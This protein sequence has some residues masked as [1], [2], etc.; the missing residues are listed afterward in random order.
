MRMI[1]ATCLDNLPAR[2]AEV[3]KGDGCAS[4]GV[5]S[6][7]PTVA[8]VDRPLHRAPWVCGIPPGDM[9]NGGL[10][11]L[12]MFI[13]EQ[14]EGKL[15]EKLTEV[16]TRDGMLISG[17]PMA[18][19]CW[20]NGPEV[21]DTGET[22][23]ELVATTFMSDPMRL[24]TEMFAW[25]LLHELICWRMKRYPGP[26]FVMTHNL[27]GAADAMDALQLPP[28]F[29]HPYQQQAFQETLPVLEEGGSLD[30]FKSD[31]KMFNEAVPAIGYKTR[32]FRRVVLPVRAAHQKIE[33]GKYDEV[34]LDEVKDVGW[35]DSLRAYMEYHQ[36]Q[37]K[38]AANDSD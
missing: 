28:G 4:E 10:S 3:L 16:L 25:S 38:A 33:E 17:N 11:L 35:Q 22:S 20:R 31:L 14:L 26:I 24:P 27:M 12:N 9:M 23:L 2:L 34:Q 8:I 29:V 30:Q 37:G 7:G 15:V 6:Y 18:E 1:A 5:L 19:L 32:F 13:N 21:K 36:A